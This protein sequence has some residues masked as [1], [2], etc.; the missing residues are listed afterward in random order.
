MFNIERSGDRTILT[1]WQSLDIGSQSAFERVLA[2]L[3]A[4]AARRI[5]VSLEHC[6]YCDSTGVNVLLRCAKRLGS[7][8]TVVVAPD[9]LSRRVF[10]ACRM[11]KLVRVVASMQEALEK[12]VAAT[13]RRNDRNYA[14]S[15]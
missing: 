5:V 4:S 9:T 12:P 8:L 7:R 10:E 6:E 3:A 15:R 2:T 13:A 11:Q 14:W 1:V